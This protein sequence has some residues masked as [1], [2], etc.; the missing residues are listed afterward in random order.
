MLERVAWLAQAEALLSA[1]DTDA[2]LAVYAEAERGCAEPDRLSGGR[3]M[4]HMLRGEY[5]LAWQESDAIR[6]RGAVDPHRFWQGEAIDGRRVML[7]CLHGYGDTVM[8]LRWLPLLRARA[9]SVVVQVAPEM[10]PLLRAMVAG[11]QRT[12]PNDDEA[13]VRVGHPMEEACPV[14]VVSWTAEGE[15]DRAMWE[16][17]VECAEL[18][19]LFRAT[20]AA[21]PAP[22]RMV[23]REAVL[24][25]VRGRLGVR[26]KPRVGLVWTGSSYD[27]ARSIPFARVRVLLGN[28][29]VEFWSL[30]APENNA[31]WERYAREREWRARTF[32][33][34]EDRAGIA[35]MAAF[36]SEMDVVITID[37]LAAHV[38]GSLG[39]PVWVLLKREA[40]WRWML[41]REDTPWYPTMRL[42]RQSEAR[43]WSGPLERVCDRLRDWCVEADAMAGR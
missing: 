6:A 29:A 5:D 37:T 2:A 30:Q 15:T 13:V 4:C 11:M 26:M 24:H 14:S 12:Y 31:E 25:G 43:D 27:A 8:Y 33:A 17:Q 40:D 3:W 28:H 7:R 23:F 39:L 16:V 21:L 22:V 38:A 19:Y 18:P 20:P 41:E 32:Y 42:F 10:L 35:E 36:A 34:G 1:R 9:S